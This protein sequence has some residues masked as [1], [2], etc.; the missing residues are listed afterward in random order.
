M[1]AL[2]CILVN[3]NQLKGSKRSEVVRCLVEG[4]SIRST[5]RITGVAKNTIVKL[6]VELGTACDKFH[7]EN[8]ISP[9]TQRIQCDEIWQ[10]VGAKEK[11]VPEAHRGEYGWGD[12]WVWTAIDADNKLAV[13]WHVGMRTP[14]V[15]R[16]FMFDLASRLTDRVQLT[17]DGLGIYRRIVREAFGEDVDFAQ[18]VKK[19][20]EDNSYEKRY[21]PAVC[22][23]CEKSPLIGNP[24]KEH[25]STS[26]VERQNLT[27]RM[28]MRRFTRLIN[29]FSKKIENHAASIALHFMYYNYCRSHQTLTQNSGEAG[30]RTQ[31]TPAMAAG[32]ADHVW[33]IDELVGLISN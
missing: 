12:V 17:S 28:G 11:N 16:A 14:E 26:F 3:L 32:L 19:Y 10:F 24:D 7:D 29:A 2:Y 27:M 1:L 31:T 4:N 15:G 25:I 6:L 20:G 13:S 33:S 5:V 18:L 21:S 30:K 9:N 8:V 23:G 22:T